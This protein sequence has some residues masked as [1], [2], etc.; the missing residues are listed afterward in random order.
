LFMAHPL[1]DAKSK[2]IRTTN[3][4]MTHSERNYA[5]VGSVAWHG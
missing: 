3:Q 1:R 2:G 4:R 5:T